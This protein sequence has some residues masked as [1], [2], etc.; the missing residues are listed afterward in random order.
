MYHE[1]SYRTK[2]MNSC[3]F[4]ELTYFDDLISNCLFSRYITRNRT[5]NSNAQIKR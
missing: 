4:F 2:L 3:Q 5:I 1:Q